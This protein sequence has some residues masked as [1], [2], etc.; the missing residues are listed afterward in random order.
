[1]ICGE[2]DQHGFVSKSLANQLADVHLTVMTHLGGTR[3][4][5]VGIMR[6]DNRFRLPASIK[7]R[8]QIAA[9]VIETRVPQ[10]RAFRGIG[11]DLLKLTKHS[12]DRH[13]ETVKI[14]PV[15]SNRRR[16]SIEILV[17]TTQPFNEFDDDRV[18]PHPSWEPA[19]TGKRLVRARGR[20]TPH[21]TV[22]AS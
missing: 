20:H 18:A 5:Q 13:V 22:D 4:A 21:V 19:K 1:M 9:K 3:V 11:I 17:E 10:A 15:K 6:P 16:L 14:L 12:V 2:A 8:N 7:M